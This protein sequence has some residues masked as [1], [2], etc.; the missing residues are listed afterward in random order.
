MLPSICRE[1]ELNCLL[2]IFSML[3]VA[4]Y[5]QNCP[6]IAA[7]D[8]GSTSSPTTA[9]LISQRLGLGVQA[10]LIQLLRFSI[11]CEASGRF[12]DTFRHV[13]VVAEYNNNNRIQSAQFEFTCVTGDVWSIFASGLTDDTVTS[14]PNANFST[15]RR[16][17]CYTCLSPLRLASAGNINHCGRK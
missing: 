13:S 17:D 10:P 11:V 2:V 8:L 3:A 1:M 16:S 9:G 4:T 15:P 14:P 7:G 5:A 6:R 12:R